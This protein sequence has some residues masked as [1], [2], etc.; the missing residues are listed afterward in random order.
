ML[1]QMIAV[2]TH[3]AITVSTLQFILAYPWV[4]AHLCSMTKLCVLCPT[5]QLILTH[6]TALTLLDFFQHMLQLLLGFLLQLLL[7]FLE[8]S[9]WLTLHSASVLYFESVKA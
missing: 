9:Y 5:T 4:V 2:T 6:H 7:G 1:L 8:T 3:T